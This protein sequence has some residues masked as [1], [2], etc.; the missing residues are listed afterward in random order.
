MERLAALEGGPGSAVRSQSGNEIQKL[1]AFILE[2]VDEKVSTRDPKA[3]G[4][5]SKQGASLHQR[6]KGLKPSFLSVWTR[7]EHAAAVHLKSLFIKLQFILSYCSPQSTEK[8]RWVSQYLF[9]CTNEE[10]QAFQA[11]LLS[12]IGQL[13]C[14]TLSAM[15]R[16]QGAIIQQMKKTLDV[17]VADM[18]K[19]AYLIPKDGGCPSPGCLFPYGSH[20]QRKQAKGRSLA[21]PSCTNLQPFVLSSAVQNL[22]T[23]DA[24]MER[25]AKKSSL[26]ETHDKACKNEDLIVKVSALEVMEAS[27]SK[28][29][30]CQNNLAYTVGYSSLHGCSTFYKTMNC[31]SK[32][33]WKTNLPKQPC[34]QQPSWLF[35]NV[36]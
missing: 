4:L 12:V 25:F 27:I 1:E 6:S 28:L 15:L 5:H 29:H 26:K 3:R 19:L 9:R 34:L 24:A 10:A 17:I 13:G 11:V 18:N 30:V 35:Y 23:Y 33:K 7:S 21:S 31:S 22:M 20:L 8:V 14:H 36:L 32:Q 2:C 16:L